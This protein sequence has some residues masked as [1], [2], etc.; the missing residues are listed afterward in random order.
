MK[1]FTLPLDLSVTLAVTDENGK[2]GGGGT[3]TDG[4]TGLPLNRL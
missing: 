2:V 1:G 4:R 3:P